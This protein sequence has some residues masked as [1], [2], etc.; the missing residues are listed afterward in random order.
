LHRKRFMKGRMQS[1]AVVAARL[2]TSNDLKSLLWKCMKVSI[3]IIL[4]FI[5]KPL[6]FKLTLFCVLTK[7]GLIVSRK[8]RVHNCFYIGCDL[9]TFTVQNIRC[10]F[11]G[12]CFSFELLIFCVWN[13]WNMSHSKYT[14]VEVTQSEVI[15]D[16]WILLFTCKFLRI[17]LIQS[18]QVR[19]KPFHC[20][21]SL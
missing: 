2:Y 6:L 18:L 17:V 20:D 19:L 11:N 5:W 7:S 9:N 16:V 4:Q 10:W 1:I 12:H 14:N 3:L 13:R 21:Y 8:F 15:K